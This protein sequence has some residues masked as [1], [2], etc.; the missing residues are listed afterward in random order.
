MGQ[1]Q[2]RV[3]LFASFGKRRD[4]TKKDR[5]LIKKIHNKAL[6]RASA[7]KEERGKVRHKVPEAYSLK[8]RSWEGVCLGGE[9]FHEGCEK[10]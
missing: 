6:E 8:T 9:L 3:I 5:T 7:L 1:R 2:S 4:T 10:E